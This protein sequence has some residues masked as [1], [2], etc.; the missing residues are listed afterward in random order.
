MKGVTILGSTGSIGVSTLDVCAR[1][2]D[3]F[4]V[5]ALAARHN[6]DTLLEQCLAHRPDY[7]VLVDPLAAGRLAATLAAAGLHTKV[8]AGEEGLVEVAS[9]PEAGIVMAAIVGAA[10]LLP[11]LAAARAGKQV[12]LANK[13]SLVCAGQLLMDA[14]DAHGAT[15]LPIDSEHNAVFQCLPQGS[16]AG[17]AAA[18]VRR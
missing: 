11:T 6:V 3:R 12:M 13:E 9:L 14:V 8:L 1:H 15:L 18:G 2:P 5:V 16:R 7:A 10:G 4:R 17:H